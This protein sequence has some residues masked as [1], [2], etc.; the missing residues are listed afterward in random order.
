MSDEIRYEVQGSIAEITIN[1]PEKMNAMTDPMYAAIGEAIQQAEDDSDVRCIVVTGAGERAFSA[2]HDLLE[3]AEAGDW[4]PWRPDRFDTGLECRKPTIAAV[5][6]YCLAGGLELALFCDIRLAA[7]TA[8]FGC[9]EVR[10]P[11]STGTAPSGSR[12]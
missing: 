5:N 2:G 10:W 8:Q 6:G 11:S 1:R 9:P 7:D 4:R 3:F 12:A